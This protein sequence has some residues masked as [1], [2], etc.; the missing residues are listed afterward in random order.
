MK[1]IIKSGLLIIAALFAF[2][3]TATAQNGDLE[4]DQEDSELIF[5]EGDIVVNAGIGIAPTYSWANG[6]L[7]IPFGGG[8]EYGVTKLEDGVIGIGADFGI[9]SGSDLTITY[10]GLEG[11]Y[12]LRELVEIEN[13]NI[14]IYAG[15]GIY[16]RSFNYSGSNNFDFST[17]GYGGYFAG[18]RYYFS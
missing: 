17:G 8:V 16:Y 14:D 13:E 2:N 1:T 9:A 11:S 4:E 5:E 3:T 18:T 10:L 7:G 6:S 15:L 12:H